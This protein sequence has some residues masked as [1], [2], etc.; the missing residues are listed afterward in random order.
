LIFFRPRLESLTFDF[1]TFHLGR[2]RG[3]SSPPRDQWKPDTL[4][5]REPVFADSL[6]LVTLGGMYADAFGIQKSGLEDL[7]LGRPSVSRWAEILERSLSH[8]QE[9]IGFFTSGS[10][11]KPH[12]VTYPLLLLI[13]EVNTFM[14]ILSPFRRIVSLVD[15]HHIYGFL[16]TFLLPQLSSLPVLRVS[17]LGF[18]PEPGDLVVTVPQ[19]LRSW[20]NRE[21]GWPPGVQ[22]LT[23]TAPLGMEEASWLQDAGV[24]Y[25]EIYGASETAGIGTRSSGEEP[26]TLLPYWRRGAKDGTLERS[27]LRGGLFVR[28]LPDEVSWE[29]DRKLIPEGRKDQAVQVGGHNVYPQEIRRFLENLS[30]VKAARVRVFDGP[31]GPRLKAFLVPQ[32]L[33]LLQNATSLEAFEQS[34]RTECGN[35]LSS[36]QRPV[37][38][39]FGSTIPTTDLGKEADWN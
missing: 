29:G 18:R 9:E 2:M 37:R 10:T 16:F 34:I 7:L 22:L 30:G 23:S 5:S 14:S 33:V 25:L 11:G 24:Q 20:R 4:I 35:H 1:L 32:D 38:F 27:D 36:P 28:E 19:I 3:G 21:L 26:F 12:R 6:E 13:E 15:S 39:T 31:Q 8:W 17:P